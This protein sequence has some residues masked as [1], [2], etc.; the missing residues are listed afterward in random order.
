MMLTIYVFVVAALISVIPILVIFKVSL[1]Q[2]KE[3]PQQM[4]RVQK[5]F[6]IGAALSKI[7]PAI[8]LILGIIKMPSG[9]GMSHLYIPWIII[10]A[11]VIYGFYFVSTQKKLNV[12]RD[13]QIAINTLVTITRPH[14][15][16]IPIMA[17]VFLFLMTL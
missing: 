8:L 3:D 12:E 1:E 11:V 14:L 4:P 10:V 15:F 2:L 13:A 7:L 16:T 17:I 6:F 5:R 9:I